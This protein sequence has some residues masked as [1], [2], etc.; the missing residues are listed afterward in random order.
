VQKAAALVGLELEGD[1]LA[2]LAA[3]ARRH[4][5]LIAREPGAIGDLVNGAI[6]LRAIAIAA[7]IDGDAQGLLK[8]A[9]ALERI[10]GKA[11]VAF[12]TLVDILDVPGATAW[13][14]NDLLPQELRVIQ[15]GK[16]A[17]E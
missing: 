9:E 4:A 11:Q 17:G 16:A 1:E 7:G 2:E 8:L 6:A 12:T 14:M 10:Q 15:G 5:G 3:D 13:T